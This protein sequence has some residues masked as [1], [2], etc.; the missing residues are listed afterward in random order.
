VVISEISF[1]STHTHTH[2]HTHTQTSYLHHTSLQSFN[3]TPFAVYTRHFACV[4]VI[5]RDRP[6]FVEFNIHLIFMDPCIAV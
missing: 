4:T 3:F 2:K 6:T 5:D 1:Y